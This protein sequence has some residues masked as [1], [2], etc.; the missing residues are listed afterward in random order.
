[1]RHV[2]RQSGRL[3]ALLQ[4]TAS[5][6]PLSGR[7]SALPAAC[8]SGHAL[9]PPLLTSQYMPAWITLGLSTTNTCITTSAG[10]GVTRG[11]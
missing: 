2:G 9:P 10:A 8:C 5:T 6:G 4:R 7:L 1:M 3:V 11:R